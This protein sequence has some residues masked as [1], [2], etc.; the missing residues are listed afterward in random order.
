MSSHGRDESNE[1]A[2]REKNFTH[3]SA[4]WR[5]ASLSCPT[6][7]TIFRDTEC[8]VAGGNAPAD[9]LNHVGTAIK[10]VSGACEPTVGIIYNDEVSCARDRS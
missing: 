3:I 1:A 10:K 6:P 5:R 8:F 4:R 2:A 9:L 7:A